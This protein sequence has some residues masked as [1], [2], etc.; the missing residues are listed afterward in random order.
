LGR[1]IAERGGDSQSD[2]RD[3]REQ[4]YASRSRK[5]SR[6]EHEHGAGVT[7]FRLVQERVAF[8]NDKCGNRG[9]EAKADEPCA[10]VTRW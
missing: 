4:S 10:H 6:A 9:P 3:D 1:L 5:T 8:D 7:Y 2:C